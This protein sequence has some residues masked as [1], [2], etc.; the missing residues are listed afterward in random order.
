MTRV[1]WIVFNVTPQADDE[2]VNGA[3]IG[4][5]MQAPHLREQCLARNMLA[6]VLRQIAEDARF[7]HGERKHLLAHAQLASI[8]IHRFVAENVSVFGHPA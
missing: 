6:L 1:R 7:H 2:I 8:E 5:F 3:S 4:V